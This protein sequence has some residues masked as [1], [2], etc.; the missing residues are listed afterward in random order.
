M[1]IYYVVI[2]LT[3]LMLLVLAYEIMIF[4]QSF[5]HPRA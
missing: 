3:Y 5:A 4:I 2:T 1:A